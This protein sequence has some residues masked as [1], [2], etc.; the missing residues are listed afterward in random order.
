[1]GQITKHAFCPARNSCFLH[2]EERC[3]CSIHLYKSS[4]GHI[5]VFLSHGVP[6]KSFSFNILPMGPHEEHKIGHIKFIYF[7]W[8]TKVTQNV[9]M[10][11]CV[12]GRLF[13]KHCTADSKCASRACHMSSAKLLR[14]IIKRSMLGIN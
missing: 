9:T 2:S 11:L 1:M 10:M 3:D 5:G 6:P 7:N 4:T 12:K 13:Q 14:G 8:T